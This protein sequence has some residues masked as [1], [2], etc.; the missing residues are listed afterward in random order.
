MPIPA[1]S[2][3]PIEET[4]M[5]FLREVY[6]S[7]RQMELEQTDWSDEQKAAFLKMQFDAQHGHY[8]RHYN[9]ARFC[10]IEVGGEDV[11]RLY[12][13]DQAHDIR[14]VDITI[15]PHYRNRGIGSRILNDILETG[16]NKGIPVSI[17]VELT[18]PALKLYLRLG[19]EAVH[20]EG[21]YMLMVKA[22]DHNNRSNNYQS[23]NSKEVS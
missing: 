16:E 10:V 13:L 15:L 14:I 18:N 8:Q 21:V 5:P 11:G 20:S 17:H 6:A 9:D 12:C 7:T 2:L 23:L 19:F 1:Y 4:D 3:R 22:P